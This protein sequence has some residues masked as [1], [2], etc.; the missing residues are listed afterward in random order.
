M[1]QKRRMEL[2]IKANQENVYNIEKQK[3]IIEAQKQ[4]FLAF[5][6]VCRTIWSWR[7]F[8]RHY[9]L[10]FWLVYFSS[11]HKLKLVRD[12]MYLLVFRCNVTF[13]AIVMLHLKQLNEKLYPVFSCLYPIFHV[14]QF[15]PIRLC[16]CHVFYVH[17]SML[18]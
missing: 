3:A 17:R 10:L 2:L 18:Y 16:L 4:E 12:E 6:V 9:F 8:R 1:K 7:K 15:M 5:E 13:I 14:Y 11:C